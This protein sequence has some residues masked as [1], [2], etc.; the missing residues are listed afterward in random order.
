LNDEVEA[1]IHIICETSPPERRKTGLH[2]QRG[3]IAVADAIEVFIVAHTE[4]H[5]EQV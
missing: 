4:E 1:A 3:E 5:L 2:L